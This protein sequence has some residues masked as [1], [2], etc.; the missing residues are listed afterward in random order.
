MSSPR[1]SPTLRR[2]RL[3]AELRRLRRD[4]GLTALDVT[5]RLNWA[6]GKLTRME[7][8]EWVRPNPRDVQDLLDVYGVTDQHQREQLMAWAREGR[9]RGWW[10]P[11]R[12]MLSE[13]YT[14]FIGLEAETA[15]ERTFELAVIPGIL[16]TADYARALMSRGPAEISAAEIDHRVEI[17]MARQQILTGEDPLRLWAVIDE[18]AL[19]RPAGGDVVMRA[20]MQHLIKVAELPKVTLQVIPF[21]SGTHPGTKGP[22]TILE[23][24]ER[25]DP[26]AVYVENVAGEL[27]IEEPEEVDSFRIAFERLTAVAKSPEDTIATIA[28]LA[29]Q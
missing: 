20:Q 7:R 10:H 29:R 2:R 16:Q 26:D 9:E 4:C 28:G 6:A 14:T 3:S 11:Y 5:D 21:S 19:Q 12:D 27:F 17:R 24:R 15:T 23:F 22:F 8:G 25:Q 18:A 1:R 13:S